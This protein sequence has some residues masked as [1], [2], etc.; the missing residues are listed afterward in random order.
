[1][2]IE[3]FQGIFRRKVKKIKMAVFIKFDST[4]FDCDLCSAKK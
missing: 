3:I 2:S 4:V 1:M